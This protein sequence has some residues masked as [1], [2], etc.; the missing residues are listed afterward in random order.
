[1]NNDELTNS[2]ALSQKNENE[3]DDE[4]AQKEADSSSEKAE[5]DASH[6]IFDSSFDIS[7]LNISQ[8]DPRFIK[9]DTNT[10]SDVTIDRIDTTFDNSKNESEIESENGQINSDDHL[11]T[12]EEEESANQ[13]GNDSNHSETQSTPEMLEENHSDNNDN[14]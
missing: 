11:S 10:D 9:K 1:M 6:S 2:D 5:N 8:P 4:V 7:N 14:E 13:I 3:D 12:S